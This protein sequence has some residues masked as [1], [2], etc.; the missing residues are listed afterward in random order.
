VIFRRITNETVTRFST[1]SQ[2][3]VLVIENRSL[4]SRPDGAGK[5]RKPHP[6]P[7][8]R[9]IKDTPGSARVVQTRRSIILLF[10]K[11]RFFL[12]N[13]PLHADNFFQKRVNDFLFGGKNI[14]FEFKIATIRIS[15]HFLGVSDSH[16]PFSHRRA[17]VRKSGHGTDPARFRMDRVRSRCGRSFRRA[18]QAR[19]PALPPGF[20]FS[21]L[22]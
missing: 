10:R 21:F 18:L 7:T 4:A 1:T 13:G 5:A 17:G 19:Y 3:R 22:F 12:Q 11:S 2:L 20:P 8:P 16:M 6:H 15:S 9:L 14:R